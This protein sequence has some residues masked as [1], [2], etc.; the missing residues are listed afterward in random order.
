M[1]HKIQLISFSNTIRIY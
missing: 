1:K